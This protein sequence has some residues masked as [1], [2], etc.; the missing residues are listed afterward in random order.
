MKVNRSSNNATIDVLQNLGKILQNACGSIHSLVEDFQSATLLK[1]KILL[2]I[3]LS[4]LEHPFCRLFDCFLTTNKD[5]KNM[6]SQPVN[7]A[8]LR[9]KI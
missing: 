4:F 8:I 3:L 6:I 7:F 5:T 1:Y 9:P 2:M